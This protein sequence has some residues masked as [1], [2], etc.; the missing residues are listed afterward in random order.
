M[1]YM[2]KKKSFGNEKE[3][4]GIKVLLRP[5]KNKIVI[6]EATLDTNELPEVKTEKYFDFDKYI[7]DS[8]KKQIDKGNKKNI[9]VEK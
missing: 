3:E 1:N 4:E 7:F 9:Q 6:E 5:Y 8:V 2:K